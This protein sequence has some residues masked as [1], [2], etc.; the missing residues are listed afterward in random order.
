MTD[1]APRST[2]SPDAREERFLTRLLATNPDDAEI[3]CRLALVRLRLGQAGLGNEIAKRAA[4]LAPHDPLCHMALGETHK[5]LR[6]LPEA[7]TSLES[8]VALDK[9]NPAAWLALGEVLSQISGG[10]D[11]AADCFRQAIALAPGLIKAQTGLAAVM[12][13]AKRYDDAIAAYRMAIAATPDPNPADLLNNLGVALERLERREDAVAV[14]R[15]AAAI[16]P[17]V[18]AIHDNLGNAQLATGNAAAAEASHRRALSLG[19]KG[20]ETWSNLGNALHRQGRLDEADAAYRRALQQSPNAAKFHTNLALNLLLSGRYAEGWKEYEWRWREHPNFPAYLRDRRWDGSPLPPSLP[21]GGTLLLQAEQGYG[22][23]IQFIRYVPLL[24]SMGVSRVILAC[25]PELMRIMEVAPGLDGVYSEVAP[26]P[27]FDRAMTLLSLGGLLGVGE[28][29][30]S[31]ATPYLSVPKGAGVKLPSPPGKVAGTLKVGLAWAGRPTHGDDWSR[32]IPARLL[33][34][35]LAVP[36]ITFYSLQRGAIAERLGRPAADTLLDAADLCAD[37]ADTAAV[38]AS[39]DLIISVDT[40]VVHMAGALG[41]PVWV[42]LPPVPDFRWRMQG[43][44]TPWYPT[45][46]LFRR[47]VDCGWEGPIA[48]VAAHLRDQISAK[49]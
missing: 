19:A 6:Q 7:R 5:A 35:I 38:V 13:A 44:T 3:L 16:R 1:I 39:L 48:E 25:Q 34:P 9:T 2:A 18:A 8:A 12:M 27:P 45:M 36:A 43:E 46:R 41:K 22:D 40:A 32:S 33:D 21:A 23:T 37:F 31:T 10:A 47:G 42:L 11:K 28:R 17:D 49:K 4:A 29:E 24:K 30:I 14:L 20:S 15:T 26:L